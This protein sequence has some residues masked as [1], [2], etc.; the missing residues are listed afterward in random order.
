MPDD[1]ANRRLKI[2][3]HDASRVAVQRL[4]TLEYRQRARVTGLKG[5]SADAFERLKIVFRYDLAPILTRLDDSAKRVPVPGTGGVHFADAPRL[6]R[7]PLTLV[8]ETPAGA[9]RREA[10][11]VLNR[12]GIAR[13]IPESAAPPVPMEPDLELERGGGPG[14][15]PQT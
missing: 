11:I 15:L 14:L 4:V 12:R 13:I 9:E 6:Y 3:A 2:E 5:S 8:V 7:V 10:V 1:S